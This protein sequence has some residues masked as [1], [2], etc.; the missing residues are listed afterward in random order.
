MVS[1]FRDIYLLMVGYLLE[2]ADFSSL[3]QQRNVRTMVAPHA[4]EVVLPENVQ[5][6]HLYLYLVAT[7]GNNLWHMKEGV[8]MSAPSYAHQVESIEK[9][10]AIDVLGAFEFVPREGTTQEHYMHMD[11]DDIRLWYYKQHSTWYVGPGEHIGTGFGILRVHGTK[12][13]PDLHGWWIG[14]PGKSGRARWE[15]V[16]VETMSDYTLVGRINGGAKRLLAPVPTNSI[17]HD[18]VEEGEC[19]VYQEQGMVYIENG[20]PRY[21][22][23]VPGRDENHFSLWWFASMESWCIGPAFTPDLNERWSA[24][25]LRA[26]DPA[27]IPD[28][29]SKDWL[30]LGHKWRGLEDK[31]VS[32][33][34]GNIRVGGSMVS[35]V[36]PDSY[37]PVTQL[38]IAQQPWLALSAGSI[39][40]FKA[41]TWG[42]ARGVVIAWV[43]IAAVWTC[44]YFG[45]NNDSELVKKS[46]HSNNTDESPAVDEAGLRN[47]R[48][49]KRQ[50]RQQPPFP[51]PEKENSLAKKGAASEPA[52]IDPKNS[53]RCFNSACPGNSQEKLQKCERCTLAVY[54]GKA[55]QRAHWKQHKHFCKQFKQH[56]PSASATQAL[57]QHE[58]KASEPEEQDESASECVVCLDNTKTHAFV[59]CGHRC[60]CNA[61]AEAIF[62][63]ESEN[64]NC[65]VCRQPA[66]GIMRVFQ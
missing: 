36:V 44:G 51:A 64:R 26:R 20:R 19:T 38:P 5:N 1:P 14:T 48:R 42:V 37:M 22:C 39:W 18:T 13:G 55:C 4:V 31:K 59:P 56:A 46:R 30:L 6:G 54:C 25:H 15:P 17:L 52:A 21:V 12:D 53:R 7:P 8:R 24:C 58:T 65:P 27:L 23:R 45:F 3:E 11:T 35:Y 29:I 43:L 41:L 47:R 50:K 61:C 60:A 32:W 57:D 62:V 10:D 66:T 28:W 9:M 40:F 63:L 2:H 49:T 16:D 33:H 34:N